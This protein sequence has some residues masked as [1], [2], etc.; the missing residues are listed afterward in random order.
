VVLQKERKGDYSLPGSYRPVALENTMA[1][2]LETLVAQRLTST[3]EKEALLPDT[4]FG[5]RKHRSTSSALALITETTHTVWKRDPRL[6]VS[7]I[8][9]DLSAAFDNVSHPRLLEAILKKGLPFWIQNFIHGFLTQRRT[10]LQ[11]DGAA[12]PEITTQTGIPQGSPLSPILFLLFSSGLLEQTKS[13]N[14]THLNLGF[15]DDTT[16]MVWG[17]TAAGN[18]RKLEEIQEIC[19]AWARRSGAVF[20]P[21]KYELIHLTRR[22]KVDLS[23]PLH[24]QGFSGEA[25]PELRVLG[26]QVDSKLT[27][28]KHIQNL[29][30]NGFNTF[31]ALARTTGMTW[32]LSFAKTRLLYN[33][34]LRSAIS[35]GAQIWAA[36]ESEKGLPDSK[37]Q[38][39]EQLQN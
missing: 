36:G 24:I 25:V 20:N 39:L 2:V 17:H 23:A 12:S 10:C 4:Q 28:G 9:L 34:T 14:D 19:Q 8:N 1:K 35:Y 18:C 38:R 13:E 27:W 37:T 26:V 33:A 11:F 7:I 21:E 6:I 22:R 29:E 31:Q 32:G 16:L 3:L 30:T 15:V 5:A